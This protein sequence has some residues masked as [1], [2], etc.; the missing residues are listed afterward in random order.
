MNKYRLVVFDFD[1]TIADTA[2]HIVATSHAMLRATGFPDIPDETI[3]QTIGLP[4][5][6]CLAIMTR[7][8][9]EA[10]IGHC[11]E[12]YRSLFFQQKEAIATLFPTVR[13]TLQTIHR[14]GIL[15][16]VAT[17]RSRYSLELLCRQMGI[18]RMFHHCMAYED[19]EQK[20]PAPEMV[21]KLLRHFQIAACDTLVVGDTIYDIQMGQ[22]AG[23]DTCGVT[24][25]NHTRTQLTAQ[26]ATSVID[27]FSDL[28]D[29]MQLE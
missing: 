11:A 15:M 6:Q 27:R 26:Q 28:L 2:A 7:C 29:V 20:K 1:G 9:D 10:V 24:Y 12:V 25:G 17:S 21:L 3:R 23:C 13:E 14:H 16:G 18:D 8:N 19:A 22:R 5:E 4:F